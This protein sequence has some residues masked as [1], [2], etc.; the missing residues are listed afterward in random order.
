MRFHVLT[1]LLL[2]AVAVITATNP[3]SA[4][5]NDEIRSTFARFINAQNAHDLKAVGN[6]LA[7]SPD[8]LWISQGHVVRKRDAALERFRNLFKGKWRVDPDWSTFEIVGLDISTMEVFVQVR[9]SDDT[10]AGNAQM[11]MILVNTAQGW[12]VQN[13]FVS[14]G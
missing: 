3:V 1:I 2:V 11:S 14:N 8:F 10:S 5:P 13:I 4:E 6:L 7:D 12:R 9:M